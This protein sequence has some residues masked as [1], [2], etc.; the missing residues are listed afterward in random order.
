[1]DWLN[2]FHEAWAQLGALGLLLM[3][4]F[5]TLRQK[6]HQLADKDA[7]IAAERQRNAT[8]NDRVFDVIGTQAAVNA[9]ILTRLKGSTP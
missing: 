3:F 1:M 8:I 2:I 5:Y 9:E 7:I 6:D 4:G